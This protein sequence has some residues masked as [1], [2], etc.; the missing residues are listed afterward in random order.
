MYAS[1]P[2]SREQT[3]LTAAWHS[4]DL[5]RANRLRHSQ[6]HRPPDTTCC[7]PH[8]LARSVETCWPVARLSN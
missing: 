7:S 2:T 5:S 8:C 3:R 1:A 6:S 4:H